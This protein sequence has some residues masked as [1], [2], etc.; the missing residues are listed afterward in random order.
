MRREEPIEYLAANRILVSFNGP[1]GGE[2]SNFL[3]PN[4]GNLNIGEI[5]IKLVSCGFPD[6][7]GI[8]RKPGQ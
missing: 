8:D 5:L 2:P 3:P 4:Q 1:G 6:P 7:I